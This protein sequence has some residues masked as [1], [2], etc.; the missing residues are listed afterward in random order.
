MWKTPAELLRLGDFQREL[1]RVARETKETAANAERVLNERMLAASKAGMSATE[2]AQLV[3]LS[4][5]RVRRV[6][7]ELS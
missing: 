6:I 2:I 4:P 1:P 5:A 7:K 3:E